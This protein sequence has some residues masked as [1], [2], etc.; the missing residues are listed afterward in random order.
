MP[1]EPTLKGNPMELTV[2]QHFHTAHAISKFYDSED[3]V[4][5]TI[6]KNKTT[7]KMSNRAKIFCTKRTWDQ[8]AEKG[9]MSSI[10]KAFHEE[11]GNVK[12]F[13]KRNHEALSKYCLLWRLRHKYH[14][15]EIEDITLTGVTGSGLTKDE[16][17]ILEKKHVSFVREGGSVPSRFTTGILIKMMFDRD[18]QTC[19]DFKWGLLEASDGEF[20]VADGYGDFPFIPISPNFA[21][22]AGEK[23]QKIN[24]EQLV[25]LNNISIKIAKEFYFAR[26]FRECPI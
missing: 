8:R 23:D 6:I 22:R 19:C 10:E 1:F 17:E 26:N 12:C 11:I 9:Y 3:K 16:E 18:W 20:I 21:F 25:V 15:E 24:R 13:E 7:V 4:E 14:L 2:N 5:V